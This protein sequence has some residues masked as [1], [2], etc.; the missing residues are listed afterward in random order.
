MVFGTKVSIPA[1]HVAKV[2]VDAPEWVVPGHTACEALQLVG[3]RAALPAFVG[4][5]HW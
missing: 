2:I 4:A 5:S 1:A 3:I